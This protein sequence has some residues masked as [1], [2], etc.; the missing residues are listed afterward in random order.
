MLH[1]ELNELNA[2]P[3]TNKG[4]VTLE[5]QDGNPLEVEGK[6]YVDEHP[7]GSD[8]GGYV[9]YWERGEEQAFY[10]EEDGWLW[11]A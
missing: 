9:P 7:E 5:D 8:R 3:K 6:G 2:E 11:T 4:E 10:E 1:D